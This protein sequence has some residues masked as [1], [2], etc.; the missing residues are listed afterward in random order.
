MRLILTDKVRKIPPVV[1]MLG[2]ASLGAAISLAITHSGAPQGPSLKTLRTAI[3]TASHGDLTAVRILSVPA[4]A[5]IPAGVTPVEVRGPALAGK[6]GT[7]AL[8]WVAQQGGKSIYFPGSAFDTSGTNLAVQLMRGMLQTG[9]LAQVAAAERAPGFIWAAPGHTQDAPNVVLF[10]D[11]N[12]IYCHKEFN[13]M[14][15][16]VDAGKLV[17]KVVPVAFLKASSIGKA[18]AILQGGL[19][20]YLQD[21]NS[22]DDGT[23]EGGI[24]PISQPSSEQQI[25]ANTQLL[26][27]LEGGRVATPFMLVHGNNGWTPHMGSLSG[28]ALSAKVLGQG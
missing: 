23:E 18:E 2:A 20:A 12:C 28:T 16:L 7:P 13:Q 14:K 17:V 19:P 27:K 4:S 1:M 21:E 24:T 6:S 9:S 5:A 25:R 8:V 3:S 26:S 22:F 15:P 10:I 11:P